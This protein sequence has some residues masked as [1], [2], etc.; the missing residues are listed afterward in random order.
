M[1]PASSTPSVLLMLPLMEISEKDKTVL[2]PKEAVM[3]LA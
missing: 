3:L 2:S 1:N